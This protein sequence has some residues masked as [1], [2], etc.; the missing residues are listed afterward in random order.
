MADPA[1]YSHLIADLAKSL[2][3]V[4]LAIDA[5][6]R[7]KGI[8][9][10]DDGSREN[11]VDFVFHAASASSDLVNFA[12]TN[13]RG[14]LCVSISPEGADS[15]GFVT[16]PQSPGIHSHTG[17]TISV[18]A[19]NGIGSG[20]S[21]SDRAQTIRLMGVATSRPQDF[22]SP[23][24]VFPV[25][26]VPGG[27]LQRTG[28]TEA[29][30]EICRMAG[31][32]EAAAMCEILGNDGEAL[33]VQEVMGKQTQNEFAGLASVS[34]VD[35]LWARVLLGSTGPAGPRQPHGCGDL[36]KGEAGETALT[37]AMKPRGYGN[38]LEEGDWITST[39]I[40]QDH[41]VPFLL[42]CTVALRKSAIQSFH[43]SRIRYQIMTGTRTISG[44]PSLDTAE[45]CVSVFTQDPES[46]LPASLAEFCDLSA[47]EG[48]RSAPLATKRVVTFLAAGEFLSSLKLGPDPLLDCFAQAPT[49]TTPKIAAQTSPRTQPYLPSW[50]SAPYPCSGQI[51]E[52][53]AAILENIPSIR[54]RA[55]INAVLRARASN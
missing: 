9:I 2:E 31:L 21:A 45:A 27:L 16:A 49:P 25:R 41:L 6:R 36:S 50:T 23:G 52:L 40:S 55:F 33:T 39:T 54:D 51:L 46:E 37:A 8:L 42:P 30:L 10:A 13:C 48:I 22:I 32:T 24:H 18:D 47:K 1:N 29:V 26:A 14:L 3:R 17:F 38:F 28:H 4:R 44:G 7:G 20:I 11:E 35:L 12:L 19:R 5:L 53:N 34:T 15:L 43:P